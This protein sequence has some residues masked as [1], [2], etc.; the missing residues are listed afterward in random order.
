MEKSQHIEISLWN[1]V[2]NDSFFFPFVDFLKLNILNDV[3]QVA[4]FQI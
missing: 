2:K 3:K 4:K 1:F